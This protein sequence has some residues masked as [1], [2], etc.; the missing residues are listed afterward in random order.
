[1]N[2][3]VKAF[4]ILGIPW[5]PTIGKKKFNEKAIVTKMRNVES[6]A[7]LILETSRLMGSEVKSSDKEA[8]ANIIKR[9]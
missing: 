5:C 6:E 3:P 8:L 1:M 9:I 7:S 4:Q 2:M